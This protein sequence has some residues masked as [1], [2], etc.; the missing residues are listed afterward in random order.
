VVTSYKIGNERSSVHS[1]TFP[2]HCKVFL[3]LLFHDH[4]LSTYYVLEMCSLQ[5]YRGERGSS[6]TEFRVTIC[7]PRGQVGHR[8][9]RIK[10]SN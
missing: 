9:F 4:F 6:V 2:M 3:V 1:K 10:P 5:G 7:T 8:C